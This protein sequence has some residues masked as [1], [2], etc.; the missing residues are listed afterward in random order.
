MILRKRNKTWE[1]GVGIK[2]LFALLREDGF[3]CKTV[4][5]TVVPVGGNHGEE[6]GY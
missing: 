1:R 3:I 2:G 5:G 4:C 6:S